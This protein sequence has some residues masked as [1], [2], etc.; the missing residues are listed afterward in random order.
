M[1]LP[2]GAFAVIAFAGIGFY[3]GTIN[4]TWHIEYNFD[5]IPGLG[6]HST[7]PFDSAYFGKHAGP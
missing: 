2:F 3:Q 5:L 1:I 7:I 6:N 4:I